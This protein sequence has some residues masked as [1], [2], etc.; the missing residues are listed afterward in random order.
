MVYTKEESHAYYISRRQHYLN[1]SK[2]KGNKWKDCSICSIKYN[3]IT[4][5]TTRKHL[6]AE[7]SLLSINLKNTLGKY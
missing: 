7:Q 6:I 5:L 2:T 3:S 4:H 1:Y